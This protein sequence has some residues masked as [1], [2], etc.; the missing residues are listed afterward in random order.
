MKIEK[1]TAIICIM[2]M[3]AI[4]FGTLISDNKEPEVSEEENRMLAGMPEFNFENIISGNFASDFEKYMI[5]KIPFRKS[6]INIQNRISDSMSIVTLEDI[7][8][9]IDTKEVNQMEGFNEEDDAT[10]IISA[11]ET[12]AP[13]DTP[14]PTSYIT[15]EITKD[16]TPPPTI[17]LTYTPEPTA[18]PD[19]DH[20]SGTREAAIKYIEINKDNKESILRLYRMRDIMEFISVLNIYSDM[21]LED[22]HVVFVN[23]PQSKNVY[24]LIGIAGN[25]NP[26]KVVDETTEILDY[27]TSEK[28]INISV[29]SILEEHFNNEEYMYYFSDTH[30]TN[31]ACHYVYSATMEKIGIE[32]IPWEVYENE[33]GISYETPF[34]GTYYRQSP[35]NV[36]KNNPDTLS[37]ITFP[38]ASTFTRY[39]G[40]NDISVQPI[41]QLDADPEDRYKINYGGPRNIGPLSVIETTSNTGRNAIIVCDSF[42]LSYSQMLI[43]H[44]DN[45]CIMDLRYMWYSPQPYYIKD[46]VEKYNA[47]DIYIVMADF[48][49]YGAYYSQLMESYAGK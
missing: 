47:N 23:S 25:D 21:L 17:T 19:P 3:F 2:I 44:Y 39:R 37:Y 40:E 7:L 24:P 13:S 45:V 46:T 30:W 31:M 15:A 8:N 4:G 28:V 11:Q 43:P 41:I 27:F 32:P 33:Y 9:V 14:S 22:G 16:T 42:G 18:T 5:D 48:N 29:M 35:S 6:I 12:A 38:Q 10:L 49:T 20:F 36:Y 34:L 1:I 26:V